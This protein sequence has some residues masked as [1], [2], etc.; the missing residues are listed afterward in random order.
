[1]IECKHK[2]DDNDHYENDDHFIDRKSFFLAE[3]KL[4]PAH[5]NIGRGGALPPQFYFPKR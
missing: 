1:M 3:I 4:F 2:D 5:E